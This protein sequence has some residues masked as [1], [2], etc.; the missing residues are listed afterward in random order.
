LFT[1]VG[2]A[3]TVVLLSFTVPKI[4]ELKK[5]EIDSAAQTGY[6]KTKELYDQHVTPVVSRIP[7]ASNATS[8]NAPKQDISAAAD[9]FNAALNAA[10]TEPKKT[11]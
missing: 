11:M 4:Y 9:S 3:Y 8:L 10:A 7:R 6:Q 5:H 2:W 1:V